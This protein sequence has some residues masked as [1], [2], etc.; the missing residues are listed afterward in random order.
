ML[1][2][3]VIAA[4]LFETSTM[5]AAFALTFEVH[6]KLHSSNDTRDVIVQLKAPVCARGAAAFLA[7]RIESTWY[8]REA[9]RLLKRKDG[10]VS[11]EVTLLPRQIWRHRRNFFLGSDTIN[12]R[13]DFIVVRTC[14]RRRDN[15]NKPFTRADPYA[16]VFTSSNRRRFNGINISLSKYKT[17]ARC[18]GVA[19]WEFID[20]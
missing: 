13:A 15:H 11:A 14:L 1:N 19:F 6:Q 12:I 2:R 4:A 16:A 20:G 18:N 8:E 7:T 9:L 17:A 3:H 10:V 5:T